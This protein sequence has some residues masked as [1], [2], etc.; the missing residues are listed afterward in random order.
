MTG[1][2]LRGI[3][4]SQYHGDHLPGG[5]HFSRSAAVD[6]LQS[7]LHCY[8]R[9]PKLGGRLEE[10]TAD[11]LDKGQLIHGLL[12]GEGVQVAIVQADDWRTKAAREARDEARA[13]GLL[14]VLEG[15]HVAAVEASTAIRQ[16]LLELDVDLAAYSPEVTA[17]W[18]ESGGT[19]CKARLDLL[20]LGLGMIDDLKVTEEINLGAFE[21]GVRALGLDIQAHVYVRAVETIHPELAGR[22]S[23]RWLL[24]ERKPPYDV[25]VIPASPSIIS[26]LGESRWRRA[27]KLWR[28]CLASGRWPGLGHRPP[29]EARPF[30]LEAELTAS[31]QSVEEPDWAKGA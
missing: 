4:H 9:H 18:E 30:D 16:R 22:V 1:Q 26:L 13:A 7:P 28:E 5:P 25:A 23:F 24:C 29:M 31:I 20:H 3:P 15:H 8:A 11:H 17:L 6:I 12:L 10:E 14:P 19:A 2:L 27:L 21:R